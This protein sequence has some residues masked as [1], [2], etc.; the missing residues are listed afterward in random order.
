MECSFD[1]DI[2]AHVRDHLTK[3]VEHALNWI[4]PWGIL[5]VTERVIESN[6]EPCCNECLT[7]G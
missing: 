6:K 5:N 7:N 1:L 2:T 3:A 4:E